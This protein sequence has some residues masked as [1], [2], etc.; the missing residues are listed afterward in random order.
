MRDM[1]RGQNAQLA[2]QKEGNKF[3]AQI[4]MNKPP[5]VQRAEIN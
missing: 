3:L 5:A 1:V 4:A 2:A